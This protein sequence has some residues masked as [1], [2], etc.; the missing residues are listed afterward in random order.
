[1]AE[2]H[3][4]RVAIVTGAAG[5]IGRAISEHLARRGAKVVLVD[6]DDPSQTQAA[7]GG[8]AMTA[9][10]DVTSSTK[11]AELVTAVIDAYGRVDILINNA[12]VMPIVPIDETDLDLWRNTFA[13]NLEAHFIAA[14]S[15]IGIMRTQKY[16]RIISLSSNT[17]GASYPGMCAYMASKMGVIGFVRGLANDLGNDGITVNAVMPGLTNTP[18]TAAASDTMRIEV[19]NAQPIKRLGEPED[20]AGPVSFLASEEAR[21]ITGQVLVV[22]GGMYKIS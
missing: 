21:H 18:G 22:D 8:E 16:G 3:E 4:G 5:G 13:I 11:W 20:V 9:V 6:K 14:K 17:I 7:V 12:G 19:A 1:M 2:T 15:V 10:F